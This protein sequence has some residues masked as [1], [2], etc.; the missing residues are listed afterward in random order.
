MSY[1]CPL[2]QLQAKRAAADHIGHGFEAAPET[3]FDSGANVISAGEPEH[4]SPEFLPHLLDRLHSGVLFWFRRP[5]Q[6]N[7]LP[8]VND[9]AAKS[10]HRKMP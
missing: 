4:G 8:S 6:F 10:N 9:V 5:N 3:G 7:A 2:T 1:A